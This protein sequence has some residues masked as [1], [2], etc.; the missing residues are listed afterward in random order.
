VKDAGDSE[1]EFWSALIAGNAKAIAR[2]LIETGCVTITRG[3]L[4]ENGE[5]F[6]TI[7]IHDGLAS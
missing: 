4:T 7:D 2:V 3:H 6:V 1:V 5:A